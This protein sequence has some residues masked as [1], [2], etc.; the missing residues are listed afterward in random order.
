MNTKE[1]GSEFPVSEALD[2]QP[3]ANQEHR[4][5]F[6]RRKLFV[7][8]AV[9]ALGAGVAIGADAFTQSQRNEARA[10]ALADA[11]FLRGQEVIPFYGVHQAGIEM[12]PQSHQVLISLNLKPGTDREQLRRLLMILSD[13]SARLTQGRN[14]LADSEP[15]LAV[16]PARLTITFGFSKSLVELVNP[17]QLPYW[18]SDLPHFERDKLEDEWSGGDL[19]LQVAADDPLTVAHAQRMLLKDARSFTS[20][21]WIQSGF[22]RS[23][24]SE[25]DSHTQR[26]LMGQLDGTVNMQAGTSDFASVVWSGA[27]SNP[28]WLEGGT[29]MVIR[30]IRM[31]LDTWDLLDRSGRE[32][33]IGRRIESGAPL[34]GTKEHDEPDYGA[35]NA[36]GFPVIA[37][38]AHIRRARP[39]TPDERMFRRVYN[40]DEVPKPGEVSDSGLIF[41]AFQYDVTRQYTP[42]QRRLDDLD[43]L[44]EWIDHIGSAVFAIPPGCQPG[45]F[46]GD[47]LFTA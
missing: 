42:V 47:S 8:G 39:E 6:S 24:G 34:T 46:V 15:E 25:P 12:V 40:F 16:I 20:I 22:R 10:S 43:L 3:Q 28:A 44:N 26:N 41:T 2:A 13:D 23:Y 18:L 9:A 30:R 35:K 14:A 45:G 1:D 19:L 36:L 32:E 38:F 29:G 17:A 21:A 37:E 4:S 11:E 33:S 31:R 5:G 7:G 27:T